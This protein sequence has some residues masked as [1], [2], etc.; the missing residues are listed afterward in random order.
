MEIKQQ[1]K[2]EILQSKKAIDYTYL[3]GY[4]TLIKP[5]NTIKVY[6]K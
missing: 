6:S 1:I 3:N 5:R 2:I 4:L